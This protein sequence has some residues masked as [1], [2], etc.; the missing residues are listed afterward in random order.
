[1]IL[2]NKICLNDIGIGIKT[3]CVQREII[4]VNKI[5]SK[6]NDIGKQNVPLGA[7]FFT[8]H[9]LEL[10]LTHNGGKESPNSLRQ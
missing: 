4:L 10:S 2:V 5:C 3:K 1:M 6:R 9:C 7:V 8:G